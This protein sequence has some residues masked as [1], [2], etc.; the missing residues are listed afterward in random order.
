MIVSIII[1]STIPLLGANSITVS[2]D[3]ITPGHI[4]T[5]VDNVIL[6]KNELT[7]KIVSSSSFTSTQSGNYQ[8]HY[9]TA[10]EVAAIKARMGD[11]NQNE[12]YNLI[13]NGSGTGLAP[14]TDDEWAAM[15]GTVKVVD[16]VINFDLPNSIDHSSSP[17]FPE[18]RSQGSQ[19]SCAAWIT[20]Y[21]AHG[22]YQ[23][24]EYKWN[25]ASTGDNNQL[26]S[27]AWTY[28]KVNKGYN[29][30]STFYKNY[31]ILNTIGAVKWS[32]MP[33][34]ANE[35]ISWGLE[36][37]WREAPRYR[38]GDYF[39]TSARNIDVLRSWLNDGRICYVSINS[40]DYNGLGVNDSIITSKDYNSTTSNHANA[41][42]GYDD[43]MSADGDIGAF[44]LANSWGKSW[45]NTK[46]GRN[47]TGGWDGN[48]T[49]W[50]TYKAFAQLPKSI[51][52]SH[53]KVDYEPKLLATWNFTGNVSRDAKITLGLGS[54]SSPDDTRVLYR[55]AG[56]HNYPEWMCLDITEFINSAGLSSFFLLLGTGTNKSSIGSFKIELYN[57]TY[58]TDGS[59]LTVTSDESPDVPKGTPG[60]VNNT[61]SGFQV[62]INAPTDDD[63]H[64][65]NIQCSGTANNSMIETVLF[66]DF[67]NNFP[68]GWIVGDD[69]Q[70][71]GLDHWGNSSARSSSGFKS[72]WCAGV[73]V[74]IFQETFDGTNGTL[75]AGWNISSD[76]TT[77][78]RPWSLNNTD[79]E[80][81][82]NGSDYGAVCNSN[83][84]ANITELLF[85]TEG[86]NASMYDHLSLEFLLAYNHSGV[87]DLGQVLYAN[88]SSYPNFTA[89]HTWT[90]DT[91]GKQK[92]NLSAAA[93]E[94]QVYLAFR[95]QGNNSNYMFVDDV[96]VTTKTAGNEYDNNMISYMDH[97]VNLSRFDHAN[98]KY[99]HWLD[100]E[101]NSDNLSIVYRLGYTDPWR[102]LAAYTGSSGGWKTA[103]VLLPTNATE[104]G[105]RFESDHNGSNYEGAYIDNIE[106]TGF[107]NLTKV[108]IRVDSRPWT[109]VIG[110]NNWVHTINSAAY[111]DGLHKISV[112]ATYGQ[113]AV[114]DYAYV[115]FDN[116][117]PETVTP[118]AEPPSWTTNTQPVITFEATDTASPIDY[119]ELKLDDGEFATEVSPYT[120]PPQTEGVHNITVRAHNLLGFYSDGSVKVYIDTS[121]PNS[122][123]PVADPARW[124]NNV[125]PQITFETTDTISDIDHYQVRVG[126]GNYSNQTSPYTLPVLDNG[127]HYIKVR[128]YD[129]AGNYQQETVPVFIDTIPPNDFT[130]S[131]PSG[132]T[133]KTQPFV[134]F[135]TSDIYCI[136]VDHYEVKIDSGEFEPH[137][138]P[139]ALSDL[140]NGIH[141][142]IVRAFDEAG[143]Y[144]DGNTTLYLDTHSPEPFTPTATPSGWTNASPVITFT[145]TDLTSGIDHYEVSINGDYP[146]EQ[147]SPF[148]V[149]GLRDGAHTITV[150]A[151]DLAGNYLDSEVEVYIDKRPPVLDITYPTG[152]GWADDSDLNVSWNCSDEHSDIQYFEVKLDDNK[153][154]NTGSD[155]FYQFTRLFDGQHTVQVT[156]Y[157]LAGNMITKSITF[158][159]DT[160]GPFITITTPQ[161]NEYIDSS[162]VTV[163]WYATDE[164]AEVE[165]FQVRLDDGEYIPTVSDVGYTFHDLPDGPHNV[166]VK[167]FDV[168][169]NSN[170]ESV[171][172][173]IDSTNPT[174]SILDPEKNITITGKEVSV[175]WSGF[176]GSSGID[177]FDIRLDT[178]NYKNIGKK[179]SHTFSD[180]DPG[181]HI[182]YIRVYDK[183]GNYDETRLEFEVDGSVGRDGGSEGSDNTL[184]IGSIGAVIVIIIVSLLVL[185][186]FVFKKQKQKSKPEDIGQEK[187]TAAE[188][189]ITAPVVGAG[190][191]GAVGTVRGGMGV[192]VGIAG[193]GGMGA[194]VHGTGQQQRVTEGSRQPTIV[195]VKPKS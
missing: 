183:A 158:N 89:L 165:T 46:G 163:T 175:T 13:I 50:I 117:P 135:H 156:A 57:D 56:K 85:T 136:F 51:Y 151:F 53:D 72:G 189:N 62:S 172:F 124:T 174:I 150:R 60:S 81:V 54:V 74:P 44:K 23:A 195:M 131:V 78:S 65:G 105:F 130:P 82:Y 31:K 14:T 16:R 116:S 61:V 88:R 49:C 143:N 177:H 7:N 52:M 134:S 32:T 132:W 146:F 37:G 182:I 169:G 149:Q 176:D 164:I 153:P 34:N 108:E 26:L 181:S 41:L 47:N 86:F 33:Y 180:A 160:Q 167:A 168:V 20:T 66:E 126:E 123:T 112:K 24:K 121:K 114:Y 170:E 30:G 10:N 58:S 184:L 64:K 18:I 5:P 161:E 45:G 80:Y 15:I 103:N 166:H 77:N 179:T 28:N 109:S 111:S 92:V 35:Y 147:T 137:E 55:L 194:V 25:K 129:L 59:T 84:S 145:A 29:T 155:N 186:L 21:Y 83:Q 157:D 110:T 40:N 159:L 94:D 115:V 127:N 162:S 11:H 192:G 138:S 128:A 100:S 6:N 3:R 22:Y 48:G 79:Y 71:Y 188:T 91:Y 122:F 140:A 8:W 96:I 87:N 120:L 191:V 98:L 152:D 101:P 4:T 2:V 17:Y 43:N 95:Y 118:T 173:Y 139:Y 119:Y 39:K 67:E 190:A 75:P 171:L 70:T 93:G 42:V 125:Q 97:S 9:L 90:N 193:V 27:P 178:N 76:N 113:L 148:T 107:Y 142:I 63:Y 187:D 19:S 154:I 12:K 141:E 133:N 104:L 68:D 99:D 69:D 102:I 1:T 73:Q 36:N 106:L 144:K 38:A 185:K